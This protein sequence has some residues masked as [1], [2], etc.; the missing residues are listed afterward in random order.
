MEYALEST[1]LSLTN[2]EL[3]E[4]LTNMTL[5]EI[6]RL[7]NTGSEQLKNTVLDNID[8]QAKKLLILSELK[9]DTHSYDF[10]DINLNDVIASIIGHLKR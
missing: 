4:L 1:I 3:S 5:T 10:D 7:L 2:F 6:V 8:G 9:D